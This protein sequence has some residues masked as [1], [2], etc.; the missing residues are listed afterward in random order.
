MR[1]RNQPIAVEGYPFIG[2]FAF[3]TLVFGLLGWGFLTFV[4]FL[5]TLFVYWWMSTAEDRAKKKK[6][7]FKASRVKKS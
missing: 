7:A 5:L 4:M 6:R 1:N 2:L 3:I